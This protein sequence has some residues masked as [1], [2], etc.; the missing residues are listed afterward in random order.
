[1]TWRCELGL[2]ISVSQAQRPSVLVVQG[3]PSHDIERVQVGC[4]ESLDGRH[5]AICMAEL[6]GE[7]CRRDWNH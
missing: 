1:M 7:S 4:L 2:S 5:H 6:L 3:S